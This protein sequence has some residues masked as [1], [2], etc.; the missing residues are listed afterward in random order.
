MRVQ[1]KS[2]WAAVLGLALVLSMLS[3]V[4]VAPAAYAADDK[5]KEPARKTRVT[6]TIR[7]GLQKKLAEAQKLVEEK[8]F[9]GSL[10]L[11]SKAL[12]DT[13]KLSQFERFQLKNY[14]G[15]IHYQMGNYDKA[16]TEFQAIV[17][18]DEVDSRFVED[19]Y[20]TISQLYSLLGQTEKALE[21]ALRLNKIKVDKNDSSLQAL[22]A[23]YHYQ[24]ERFKQGLPYIKRAISIVKNNKPGVSASGE[25]LTEA[26]IAK[27][28]T[29]RKQWYQLLH[30]YLQQLKKYKELLAADIEWV[31]FYPDNDTMVYLAHSL[32]AM[33]RNKDQ[34][35]VLE[36]LYERGHLDRQAYVLTLA[37]LQ[38]Q[39]GIP[40]K[41]ANMLEK[42]MKEDVVKGDKLENLVLLSRAWIEA[43]E[44][45]KSI[46]PL[47]KASK[48]SETGREFDMLAKRYIT[49]Y[50]WDK[51]EL[52]LK[53]AFKKGGLNNEISSLILLGQAQGELNKFN[54]S[55]KTLAKASAL[56]N[57]KLPVEVAKLKKALAVKS[58]RRDK[59]AIKRLRQDIKSLNR[60]LKSTRDLSTYMENQIKRMAYLDSARP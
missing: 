46:P 1:A 22:I 3:T 58:S 21:I 39:H 26:E 16:L 30:A 6:S 47:I 8:Q 12:N 55:I 23:N 19:A 32:G 56:V 44:D 17:R 7:L 45:K 10:D 41:A 60:Q 38:I 28:T 49:L 18:F 15:Y 52:A 34:L 5:K 13:K 24:L 35:S 42:A 29:P 2:K 43:K 20:F 57:R 36:L 40:Y 59:T 9:Q 11:L 37:S 51:A 48:I 53:D 27:L 4:L 31:Y 14:S 25:E 54:E 50:Q 33:E